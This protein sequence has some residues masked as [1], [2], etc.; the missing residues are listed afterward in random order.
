MTSDSGRLPKDGFA[1]L[2]PELHVNDLKAS[3]RFWRDTCGFEIAYRREEE[4]FVY[5]ERDGA[6]LMLCQRHGR[7][8]TGSMECPLGQGAMFQIY[9]SDVEPLLSTLRAMRWPLYE[10]PRDGWYRVGDRERGLRQFLV[11]DP[12]GYL[13]MFAQVLGGR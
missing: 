1:K 12:D 6:Q 7:Y 3:L 4:R 11:Q 9:L 13:V 2:V 8:E 5:L 10:Q